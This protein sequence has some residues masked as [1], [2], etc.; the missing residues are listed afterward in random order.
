MTNRFYK[1]FIARVPVFWPFARGAMA[2]D[3]KLQNGQQTLAPQEVRF[4]GRNARV[5]L[6]RRNCCRIICGRAKPQ[7]DRKA[8]R[9]N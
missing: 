3:T 4:S 6:S 8:A 1:Q 7:N 5:E 9:A 2:N